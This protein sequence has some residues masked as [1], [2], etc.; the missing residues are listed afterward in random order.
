MAGEVGGAVP[1]SRRAAACMAV[2]ASVRTMAG[3]WGRVGRRAALPALLSAQACTGGAP[4]GRRAPSTGPPGGCIPPW[5]AAS[6]GGGGCQPAPLPSPYIWAHLQD[7]HVA[8][9][10][11]IKGSV[12]VHNARP[13]RR[14][15]A[16][17][18][19]HDAARGGHE[20]R[21]G[22][23]ARPLLGLRRAAGA[24]GVAVGRGAAGLA[25]AVCGTGCRSGAGA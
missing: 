19:L 9:M 10:E 4:G 15:L 18:E 23:V 24:A 25:L 13:G 3:G 21:H 1:T 7:L 6:S 2:G 14:R 8:H 17:A 16:A 12:D 20:A 5:C 11:Q 22:D